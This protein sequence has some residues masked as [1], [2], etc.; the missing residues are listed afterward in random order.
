MGCVYS[1]LRFD[2]VGE[3]EN[4]NKNNQNKTPGNESGNA[5][6]VKGSD[7]GCSNEVHS[8]IDGERRIS[9]VQHVI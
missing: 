4:K 7:D 9:G 2:E 3:N 5:W 1:R 8:P 6:E